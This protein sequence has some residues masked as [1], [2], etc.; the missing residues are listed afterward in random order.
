VRLRHAHDPSAE[1]IE[2]VRRLVGRPIVDDD[3][4]DRLMGLREDA[5]PPVR[6]SRRG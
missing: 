6:A 4:L 5:P 3:E 1:S 2:D